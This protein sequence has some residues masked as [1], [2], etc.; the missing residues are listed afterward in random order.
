MTRYD[1]ID[2]IKKDSKKAILATLSQVQEKQIA[3]QSNYAPN[4]S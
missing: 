2:I 3:K 4:G 1:S